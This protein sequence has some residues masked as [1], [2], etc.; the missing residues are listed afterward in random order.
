MKYLVTYDI[1]DRKRWYKIFK[2]MK[3]LGLNVQLSCFEIEMSPYKFKKVM[4]EI[5]QIADWNEDSVY[6]FPLSE[7]ASGLTVKLGKLE[8]LNMDKVI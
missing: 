1:S 7:Y 6:F 2:I 8:E 4:N 5:E 3:Q